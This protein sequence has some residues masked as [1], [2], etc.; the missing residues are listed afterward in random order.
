MDIFKY[1]ITQC[2]QSLQDGYWVEYHGYSGFNS[3][4]VSETLKGLNQE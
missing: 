4:G 1:A 2:V 3:F